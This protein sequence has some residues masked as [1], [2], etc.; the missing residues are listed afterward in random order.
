MADVN[1]ENRPLS[2]HLQVY[3]MYI[4]MVVSGLHRITGFGL[5]ITAGLLVWWFVAAATSPQS[6]ALIDGILTSWFGTLVMV[7]SLWGL[8]HHFLNGIR[9][10]VWDTGSYMGL[11]S[12]NRSAWYV[13]IGA[14]L[15]TVLILLIVWLG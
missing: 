12:V 5:T 7:V 2:P 9:H 11:K 3:R 4:T 15:L 14:P 6:F 10:L 13:L 8:C 1:R